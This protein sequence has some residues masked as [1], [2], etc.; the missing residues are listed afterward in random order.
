MNK[1][2]DTLWMRITDFVAA[3]TVF[4]N[5][6]FSPLDAV[7]PAF[8]ISVIAFLTVVVA[9]ILSATFITRRF[10]ELEKQF[11]YWH[12]IRREAASSEDRKKGKWMAKSIDQAKLNR[13]Y[14]DYFFEGFM[15]SLA[16][17]Y[18]PVFTMLAYVNETYRPENLSLLT[19]RSYLFE[20]GSGNPV[21]IGGIF[22]F[23]A[24][25]FTVY[26]LW[27]V[28]KHYGKRFLKTPAAAADKSPA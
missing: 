13:V 1:L 26:I 24:C 21:Q 8:T 4:L 2:F 6:A 19:G 22:W 11:I 25:V 9:K 7:H 15:L 14:Y 3:A 27:S 10:I 20:I 23:I 28:L 12:G 16:T 17:K 5:E 18:L